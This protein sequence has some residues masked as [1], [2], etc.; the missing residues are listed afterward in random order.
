[1]T[2]NF[3]QSITAMNLPGHWKLSIHV[4][5]AG[6][7]TVSALFH[8]ENM[9]DKAAKAVPPMLLKGTAQEL[10]EGFFEA[11]EKPAQQTASLF[12][13]MDEYLKALET[14]KA[15]SRM[16]QDKKQK[17]AKVKTD[18]SDEGIEF[19]TDDK[20]AKEE[21][22]KVFDEA[23]KKV[24]ELDSQCQYEEALNILPSEEDYADKA[25][26]IVKKRTEL[27]RKREQK[28]ALLF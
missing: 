2:T 3:F 7:L 26:E 16:E 9:G 12:H 4:D 21:K 25:T 19:G 1:M 11:I 17:T 8:T 27:E 15:A 24:G 10:D 5:S 23:I 13:N 6:N 14:A 20:V 18:T 22:K 28:K